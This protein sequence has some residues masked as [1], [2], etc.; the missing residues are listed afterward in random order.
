MTFNPAKAKYLDKFEAASFSVSTLQLC[1]CLKIVRI[2]ILRHSAVSVSGL[3]LVW[4]PLL[5]YEPKP[6][7]TAVINPINEQLTDCLTLSNCL[8]NNKM[9]MIIVNKQCRVRYGTNIL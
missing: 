6:T 1:R 7:T 9:R 4:W 2:N 8:N 5:Q 3:I